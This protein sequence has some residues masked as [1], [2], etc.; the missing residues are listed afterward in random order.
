MTLIYEPIQTDTAGISFKTSTLRQ[1]ATTLKV[2]ADRNTQEITSIQDDL[3]FDPEVVAKEQAKLAKSATHAARSA[4]SVR[5]NI[6]DPP[7]FG[8]DWLFPHSDCFSSDEFAETYEH[9]K[10]RTKKAVED[11]RQVFE[12]LEERAYTVLK[13]ESTTTAPRD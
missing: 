2:S 1:G 10:R 5:A 8:P 9:I 4:K 7:D 3:D 12:D 6:R 11:P 13:P